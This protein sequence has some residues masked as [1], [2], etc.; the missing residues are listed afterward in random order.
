MND[1]LTAGAQPR[2]DAFFEPRWRPVASV[3]MS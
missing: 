1:Q 3:Q 2:D